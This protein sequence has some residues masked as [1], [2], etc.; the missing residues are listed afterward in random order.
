MGNSKDTTPHNAYETHIDK[1]RTVQGEIIKTHSRPIGK[2]VK[3]QLKTHRKLIKTQLH[4]MHRK[5]IKKGSQTEQ[6]MCNF[7]GTNGEKFKTHKNEQQW[8]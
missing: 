2:T 1:L 4:T 8:K 7:S 3:T 6:K 5:T